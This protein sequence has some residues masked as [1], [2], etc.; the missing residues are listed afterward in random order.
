MP[1]ILS[2]IANRT[3]QLNKN[4]ISEDDDSL[5]GELLRKGYDDDFEPT[6]Y[7]KPTAEHPG[8]I[9]KLLILTQRLQDG[10][11]LHH[12]NDEKKLATISEQTEL[13]QFVSTRYETRKWKNGKAVR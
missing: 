6:E 4:G 13:T 12:E 11:T 8:S 10:V 3:V 7:C 9:G 5:F 2:S 1:R